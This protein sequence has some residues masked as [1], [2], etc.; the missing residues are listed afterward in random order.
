ME[1]VSLLS[2]RQLRATDRNSVSDTAEATVTQTLGQ[3]IDPVDANLV[4]RILRRW[5]ESRD[6]S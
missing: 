4:Q 1:S 2:L 6:R 3:I 5:I